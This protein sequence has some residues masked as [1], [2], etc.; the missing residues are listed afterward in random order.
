MNELKPV[1]AVWL[2]AGRELNT[3]L[4]TRAFV[5]STIVSIVVLGSKEA[6]VRWDGP[7][8]ANVHLA[9]YVQQRTLLETCDVFLAHAGFSGVRESLAAGTPMV[10]LPL[11]ADQPENA[12]RVADL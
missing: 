12:T 4:R 3:R 7:R 6:L 2:V 8:P 1:Q 10:A 11:F 9:A 5:V